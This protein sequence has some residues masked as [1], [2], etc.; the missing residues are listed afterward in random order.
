[1]G[2]DGGGGGGRLVRTERG[3]DFGEDQPIL[4][5]RCGPNE[6]W[7]GRRGGVEM[8]ERLSRL[9]KYTLA[10][11]KPPASTPGSRLKRLVADWPCS[12]HGWALG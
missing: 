7:G 12:G 3:F 8:S 4:P 2:W 1:M 5:K 11:P 10:C 6:V 9:R